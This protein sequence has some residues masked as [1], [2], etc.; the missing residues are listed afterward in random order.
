[1]SGGW[2]VTGTDTGVGKTLV[3]CGLVRG[4]VRQ[5]LRVA[6]MKP[7]AAGCRRTAAGWRNEDALALQRCANLELD[8]AEVNPCALA[9]PLAPALAAARQ[10][11]SIDLAALAATGRDL[12][13]RADRLLVEGIGGWRVPFDDRTGVPDLAAALGL[14]VILVVALRL[15][16]INHALLTARDIQASGLALAGWVANC[17]DRAPAAPDTAE[18]LDWLE[19]ALPVP[20]LAVVPPLAPAARAELVLSLP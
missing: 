19:R 16:C 11:V 10:G 18:T 6:A 17:P 12:A 14:P 7:V 9:A 20:L 2:F 1:M 8:Y 13:G 3:T 5:G 15:G 4:L